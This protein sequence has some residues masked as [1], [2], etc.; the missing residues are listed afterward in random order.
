[1]GKN[2][3][4][5]SQRN[6]ILELVTETEKLKIKFYN[7][8]MDLNVHLVKDDGDLFDN[9]ERYKKLV[10]KLNYFKVITRPNITFTVIG[11]KAL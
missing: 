3:I 7:T 9:P 1:M 2:E 6:Y 5:L 8:P 4:F 11:S 10:R